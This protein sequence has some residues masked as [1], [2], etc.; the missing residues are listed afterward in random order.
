MVDS[1][2]R[3]C[4]NCGKLADAVQVWDE[5]KPGEPMVRK[6]QF[7]CRDYVCQHRKLSYPK[8]SVNQGWRNFKAQM[9]IEEVPHV[10]E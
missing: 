7:K 2:K 10:P 8:A 9:W 6:A 5:G 1:V 3:P 4:P